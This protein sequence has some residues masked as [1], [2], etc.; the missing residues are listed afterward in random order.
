MCGGGAEPGGRCSRASP[1]SCA[2]RP[3]GTFGHVTSTGGA[4]S[5]GSRIR[6][7]L[8]GRSRWQ[9]AGN[10]AQVLLSRKDFWFSPV[11]MFL[12][13]QQGLVFKC[14]HTAMHRCACV[15]TA[16]APWGSARE[17]AERGPAA[18]CPA[19]HHP[20]SPPRP[21]AWPTPQFFHHPRLPRVAGL[22]PDQ[23]SGTYF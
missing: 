9:A 8:G 18:G 17:P 2:L 11:C 21:P 7:G 4:C 1:H 6:A 12:K 3:P 14:H 15:L 19:A 22:W 10:A 5:R 16:A 20:V 23:L 13:T